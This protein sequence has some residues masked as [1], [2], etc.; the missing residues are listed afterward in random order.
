MLDCGLEHLHNQRVGTDELHWQRISYCTCHC[1]EYFSLNALVGLFGLLVGLE[2]CEQKGFVPRGRRSRA[3]VGTTDRWAGMP[4]VLD[5][6]RTA[7]NRWNLFFCRQTNCAKG[8][9]WPWSD[10]PNSWGILSM[11]L[12]WFRLRR[13]LSRD[14]RNAQV[15]AWNS[16]RLRLK[17]DAEV[18]QCLILRGS[19]RPEL[20]SKWF[21]VVKNYKKCTFRTSRLQTFEPFAWLGLACLL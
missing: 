6:S 21:R 14:T 20:K 10:L 15:P 1:L 12:V 2:R 5:D 13:S 16:E 18:W 9:E 8:D 19:R 11:A 7:R 17:H 4:T 3:R